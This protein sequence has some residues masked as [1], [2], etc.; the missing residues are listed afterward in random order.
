[1]KNTN[2]TFKAAGETLAANPVGRWRA[3]LGRDQ[4]ASL[5]TCIGDLLE[6]LGYE[7]MMPSDAAGDRFRWIKTAY[8]VF[9]CAKNWLKRHTRAGHLTS[10][11]RMQAA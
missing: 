5:E 1:M 8:P 4:I 3:L 10:I 11:G 9:F 7:L 2:S 6:Q